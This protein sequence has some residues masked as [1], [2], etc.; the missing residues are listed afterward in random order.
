MAWRGRE[1]DVWEF[2]RIFKALVCRE[3]LWNLYYLYSYY[4]IVLYLNTF[5]HRPKALYSIY[6]VKEGYPVTEQ[7]SSPMSSSESILS[8]FRLHCVLKREY[9]FA[10]EKLLLCLILSKEEAVMMS[11]V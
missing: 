4:N 2:K 6:E 3:S 10:P 1:S 9:F 8:H 5:Q 11:T 7:S